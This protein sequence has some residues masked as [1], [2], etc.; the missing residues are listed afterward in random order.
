MRKQA[1]KVLLVILGIGVL[2]N[3][4]NSQAATA[5][6]VKVSVVNFTYVPDT[7][8]INVGD[9]IIWTATADHHTV[10]ADNGS[11]DSSNGTGQTLPL[12]GTFSH[13]FSTA[14]TFPYHCEVHGAAGGIGMSGK[15]I[16]NSGSTAGSSISGRIVSSASLTQ[17]IGDVV[18][19][20]KSSSGSVVTT[21]TAP[22]GSYRFSAV[23][24]GSYTLTP[25]LNGFGFNPASATATVSATNSPVVNFTATALANIN[26]VI[27]P[28]VA[29]GTFPASPGTLVT[30]TGSNFTGITAV[31]FNNTNATFQVVSPVE[32]VTA[33]PVGATTGPITVTNGGGIAHGPTITIVTPRTPVIIGFFPSG[34]AVGSSVVI[35]GTGLTGATVRIGNTLAPVTHNT[36]TSITARVPAL[37]QTGPLTV[38][39]ASGQTVSSNSFMV[40]PII[41][42]LSPLSGKVGSIVTIKGLNFFGVTSVRFNGVDATFIANSSTQLTAA[43]PVG[44]TT[45]PITVTTVVGTGTSTSSFTVR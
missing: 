41:T 31:K 30:I 36:A 13:T 22:N 42:G 19:A 37:A 3:L 27:I 33:V 34:G 21:T 20:S 17:G 43:L 25:T 44:A 1:N 2:A 45:G 16:V 35:N 14:G 8:T 39:T 12:N 5:A 9:T 32:I 23:P 28:G 24:N 7:V 29:R 10:T 11:F 40:A 18:I 6:V 15:V 26:D 38:T 4:W